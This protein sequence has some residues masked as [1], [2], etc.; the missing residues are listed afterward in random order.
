MRERIRNILLEVKTRSS[1]DEE[2]FQSI[3]DKN[4]RRARDIVQGIARQMGYAIRAYH[5]TNENFNTFSK[6]E[7]GSKNWMAESAYEGFF[8]A[9]SKNT[10]RAYTGFN[11][12]DMFGIIS[13]QGENNEEVRKMNRIYGRE[14]DRLEAQYQKKSEEVL[15][16]I[17]QEWDD[18]HKDEIERLS[19]EP[20]FNEKI[21][22]MFKMGSPQWQNTL[23]LA[24]E[25]IQNSKEAQ[26]YFAI[27]KKM[28]KYLE[29]KTFEK[30]GKAKRVMDVVL[31]IENP[32]VFDY[33][34]VQ[35]DIGLTQHI[36]KAENSGHDGVIFKNL[37]DGADVDDIYVV[38]DA[39]QIKYI[40]TVT[41][42]DEG[43]VIPPSQRFNDQ[44]DDLRY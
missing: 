10:A 5:G 25:E 33:N 26:D 31:R 8:F 4:I 43:N 6:E 30:K 7:L 38:F 17:D 35:Q 42:D 32:Y 21:H 3:R 28:L 24:Y 15:D 36:K 13:I 44:T 37:A 20:W 2:Y 23:D 34:G 11:S 12:M 14:R 22:N 16:R 18:E 9:K 19:S 1:V 39:N 29:R 41:R 40:N 27:E